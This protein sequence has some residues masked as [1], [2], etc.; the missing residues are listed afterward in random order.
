[1]AYKPKKVLKDTFASVLTS[2]LEAIEEEALPIASEELKKIELPPDMPEFYKEQLK[3]AAGGGKFI[4]AAAL[5][6]YAIGAVLGL[7]LA[8]VAPFAEWA[9]M[10]L[11]RLL[12]TYRLDPAS[13][14]RLWLRGFPDEDRKEEWWDD[15]RAQGWSDDRVNAA[16]ELAH[17]LPSPADAIAFLAHE[18]FEPEMI[19]KYGLDSEFEALDLTLPRKIGMTD[20]M[21]LNYWRN[22]WTHASWMQIVE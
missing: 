7:A 22:H 6:P 10:P 11:R 9:G 12:D 8:P 3:K 13:V 19:E 15:L 20:E 1:M 21:S 2:G 17:F 16:K 18:V 5:L 4:Q 14:T